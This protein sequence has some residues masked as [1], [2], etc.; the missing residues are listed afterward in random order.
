MKPGDEVWFVRCVRHRVVAILS[1]EVSA[2]E[3]SPEYG[4]PLKVFI[5]AQDGVVRYAVPIDDVFPTHEALCEY[6]QKIFK[7]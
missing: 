3:M 7:Q 4:E 2:V 1:G 6:Y 5:R